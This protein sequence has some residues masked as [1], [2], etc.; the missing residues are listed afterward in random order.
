[1]E[2]DAK[3]RT[4]GG[5]QSKIKITPPAEIL[6]SHR[7]IAS[8]AAGFYSRSPIFPHKSAMNLSNFSAI[9]LSNVYGIGL[10]DNLITIHSQQTRAICLAELLTDDLKA[11]G[12]DL[13]S[14]CII[15]GGIAG[16]TCALVLLKNGWT[17]IT[18]LEQMPDLL[19][20][21][22]GCDTRWVHPHIINW[23]DTDSEIHTSNNGV[24]DWSSGTA[25]NVSYEIEKNWMAEVKTILEKTSSKGR[26]DRILS[27]H[28][29]VTYIHA[30]VQG[31]EINIEWIRD[32]SVRK[33]GFKGSKSCD[34]ERR[35]YSHTVFASGFGIEHSSTHSYW[36]NEGL[37][38]LH[39]DGLQQAYMVSG[40][41]DGAVSDL[42][43]LTTKNLRPDRITS[44][45]KQIK[46]LADEFR[47]IKKKVDLQNEANDSLPDAQRIS[48][49]LMSELLQSSQQ[50]GPQ[51]VNWRELLL[52]FSDLKREDTKVILFHKSND[53]F[54]VAFNKS[55]ASFFSKLLVFI[56]YRNGAFQFISD[57]KCEDVFEL[58]KK[59]KVPES[60]VI[61]RH[62][63]DR[64][65]IV[66]RILHN[67]NGPVKFSKQSYMNC[68]KFVDA[69]NTLRQPGKNYFPSKVGIAQ[70]V[71][72]YP[73]SFQTM[74]VS[75]S[76]VTK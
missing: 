55:P 35:K 76:V 49:D 69:K 17:D 22:N 38:Q 42:L 30:E 51:G 24:L 6:F 3:L 10:K 15:G 2:K 52:K 70:K 54:S 59:Y 18:I 73:W 56:L 34:S 74:P 57:A 13:R 7:R 28:V 37:G 36:R 19:A 39:I 46:N 25:S 11:Q 9:N 29:G 31:A 75:Y 1:M 43:R 67:S 63:V 62:G 66:Q 33:L 47:R 8:I 65:A 41:G 16:L 53:S 26:P 40:L 5:C 20:V 23:P 50:K 21:Q 12:R 61:R 58:A 27:V 60:N 44:E 68:K 4:R 45:I 32:S 71:N 72:K 64:E 48:Y 14:I